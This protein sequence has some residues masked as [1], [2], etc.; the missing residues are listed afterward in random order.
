MVFQWQKGLSFYIFF[1]SLL[2]LKVPNTM[3]TDVLKI[4]SVEERNYGVY[5]C[6]ASNV[7]GSDLASVWVRR[8]SVK[9]AGGKILGLKK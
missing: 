5:Q 8:P 9:E 3:S 4:E 7:G 6:E 1:I 2:I